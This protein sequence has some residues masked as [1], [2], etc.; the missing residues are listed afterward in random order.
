MKRHRR[1]VRDSQRGLGLYTET[2]RMLL[3]YTYID[4]IIMIILSKLDS[5]GLGGI[6]KNVCDRDAHG[7]LATL[8]EP[9]RESEKPHAR[10]RAQGHLSRTHGETGGES[11]PRRRK[12]GQTGNTIL[13]AQHNDTGPRAERNP[14]FSSHAKTR[15][16]PARSGRYITPDH[17]RRHVNEAAA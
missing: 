3:S 17:L 13:P 16:Q 12:Q 6:R 8:R 10:L 7:A 15:P 2:E 9:D 14:S 1:I 4:I 5:P 11:A